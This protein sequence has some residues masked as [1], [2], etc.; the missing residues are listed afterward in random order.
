MGRKAGGGEEWVDRC[1]IVSRVEDYARAEVCITYSSI[2]SSSPGIVQLIRDTHEKLAQCAE[3][4][5]GVHSGWGG[6]GPSEHLTVG[7]SP[8]QR[9]SKPIEHGLKVARLVRWFRE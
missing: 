1:Y 2:Q 3:W 9:G 4:S 5:S 7:N 8:R 6:G